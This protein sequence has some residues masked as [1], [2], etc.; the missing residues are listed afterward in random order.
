MPAQ[1]RARGD[2]Q[3][4]LA[5][6]AAGQQPGQRG[7]HRPAAPRQPG[8][9][10]LALENSDLVPQDEDL[11]VLGTAGAC[12]HGEPAEHAQRRHIGES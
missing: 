2:D 6:L 4:Q 11:R 1:E 5:E 7:Q 10:D 8:R 12:Q 3:A 9:F